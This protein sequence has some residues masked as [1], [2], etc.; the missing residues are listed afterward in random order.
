[1]GT[2]RAHSGGDY[3]GKPAPLR[4]LK[5]AAFTGLSARCAKSSTV[6]VDNCVVNL[7]AVAAKWR[8]YMGLIRLPHFLAE[9]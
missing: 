7:R 1:M 6:A 4:R 3:E 9:K 5:R 2:S 8:Q